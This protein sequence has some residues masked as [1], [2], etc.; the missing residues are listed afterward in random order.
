MADRGPLQPAGGHGAPAR[1]GR[2]FP[3][4]LGPS[5]HPVPVAEH[6]APEAP[7]PQDDAQSRPPPPGAVPWVTDR[8]TLGLGSCF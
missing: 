4:A 7:L 2:T 5:P 6:K 1:R 3:P 8:S